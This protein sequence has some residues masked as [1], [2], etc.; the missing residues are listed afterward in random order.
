MFPNFSVHQNH[1]EGLFKHRLLFA[2]A[3]GLQQ[4]LRV[5]ASNMFLGD[6]NTDLRTVLGEPLI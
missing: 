2:E 3:G 1:L 4:G 6:G 5:C